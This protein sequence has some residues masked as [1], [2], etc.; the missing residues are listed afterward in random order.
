MTERYLAVCW[1]HDL[2]LGARGRR[3]AVAA[4]RTAGLVCVLDGGRWA[5]FATPPM[6]VLKVDQD[7]GVVLGT[8]F[9]RDGASG[10]I[11]RFGAKDTDR[12]V[13]TGG[14]SLIEACWGGYVAF[15]GDGRAGA[16]HVLRDPSGAA[17]CFHA[18]RNGL[19]FVFSDLDLAADVGLIGGAIDW[20][21]VAHHLAYPGLRVARTGLVGV[22][23]LLAGTRLSLGPAG[24]T[25]IKCCWS[26][27]TFAAADH[28]SENPVE[29][30]ERVGAEA[31]RC[32]GAWASQSRS[33]LLELSGGLDSSIVAAC[34][35]QAQADVR[36]FTFATPHPGADERTYAQGVADQ[37]GVPLATV[38]LDAGQADVKR[39][40]PWRLARPGIN[41]L[42]RCVDD[43]VM[44]EARRVGAESVFTGG[45][46]DSVFCYLDTAAPAA[47]V[48]RKRGP[49]V[50][51]ARS[52]SDLAALHQCTVWRAAGLAM[53]KAYAP[54]LRSWPL[55]RQFLSDE[56]CAT[57]AQDHPWLPGPAGALPGKREQVASLMG[58]QSASDCNDR[59]EG[60]AV[61]HPLLSQPLVELCLS[62]PSWMWIAGGRNR[63]LARDA[64]ADA[65]PPVIINRRTKGDFM[66]FN[67]HIFE[68]QRGALRERL[69]GGNLAAQGVLDCGA[70]ERLMAEPIRSR[71][72]AFFRLLLLADMETWIGVWS[73]GPA[74]PARRC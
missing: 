5:V 7:R 60:A 8:V 56:A 70:I 46:G 11:E 1:P 51:F 30:I 53:K 9:R 68:R 32:V 71:D 42:Q 66:G 28:S 6:K 55:D 26:P 44:D 18:Q 72:K 3:D 73:D 37:I 63:A 43:V 33:I 49:G 19:S 14:Q 16:A 20:A 52:V 15:V 50:A 41:V 34:L 12:I 61:C 13:K 24:E 38:M 31:R 69:L 27:W 48:L 17:P 65:L 67:A 39:A 40:W 47:D 57:P 36:C 2:E 54:A 25:A 10:A 4:A 58:L 35:S 22:S 29:A 64:F 62:I 59:T 45:G 74:S 21:F 23:E